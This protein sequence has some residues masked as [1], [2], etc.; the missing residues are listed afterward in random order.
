[1]RAAMHRRLL[2][3]C[4]LPLILS[5]LCVGVSLVALTLLPWQPFGWRHVVALVVLFGGV[6]A[7]W[8]GIAQ[9]IDRFS[10]IERLRGDLLVSAET[11]EPIP[12]DR[13]GD[14]AMQ[15][16]LAEA[17][18]TLIGRMRSRQDARDRQ[19][20]T[21]LGALSDGIVL[22]TAAGQVSLINGAARAALGSDAELGT[23]L[24]DIF[25]R[26]DVAAA[27][28]GAKSRGHGVSTQLRDLD[29]R[30]FTVRVTAIGDSGDALLQ[31][32]APAGGFARQLER[33]HT[34]HRPLPPYRPAALSMSLDALP[35]V[36]LDTETTGLDVVRDRIVSIGAVS[37]RANRILRERR[38]DL[39]VDPG[40]PIPAG[41]TAI[42]GIT[43]S[44][45]A[46]HPGLAGRLPVLEAFVAGHVIVGHHVGFDLALL[47]RESG[48]AG[49]AWDTP[50]ALDTLLLYAALRPRETELDLDAVARR[51]GVRIEGR[52]TALG[53]ALVAANIYLR[54]IP[55][56]KDA[57]IETLQQAIDFARRPRRLIARQRSA[58]WEEG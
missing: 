52:H 16:G 45:V 12:I 46:G 34:L 24:Y 37:I 13:T 10:R 29:G 36:S 35:V 11:G 44:M 47:R 22:V 40:I 31:F 7:L 49:I 30:H 55:L 28:E 38:L 1:M 20:E 50:F 5:V 26:H 57:G 42:H 3:R 53:D 2:Y 17:V 21:V 54:L 19:I 15:D 18:G 48:E 6:G 58:G 25:H 39:L 9:L 41:A 56:L 33:D 32:E 43:D 4:A 51:L 23:S 8:S 14:G 27:L